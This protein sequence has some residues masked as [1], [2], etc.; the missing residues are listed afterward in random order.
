MVE[1]IGTWVLIHIGYPIGNALMWLVHQY[2]ALLAFS[3]SNDPRV[4]AFAVLLYIFWG[5]IWLLRR[6]DR[7][8]PTN[9]FVTW[10]WKISLGFVYFVFALY[11]VPL[12]L[13]ALAFAFAGGAQVV[14]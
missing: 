6:Y 1:E 13:F 11:L 8:H 12:M 9:S 14:R 3:F 2:V 7:K 5:L 4:Y 10:T